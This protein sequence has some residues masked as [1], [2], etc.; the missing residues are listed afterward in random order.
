M[1]KI[2]FFYTGLLLF[3]S[4][5][6]AQELNKVV[7]KYVSYDIETPIRVDCQYFV[8]SFGDDVKMI[9]ITNKKDL[10]SFSKI[11]KNMI[12]DT[13]QIMPD[14]RQ[15]IEVF[16]G[17]KLNIICMDESRMMIDEKPYKFSKE[18]F[19]YIEKMKK[20]YKGKQINPFNR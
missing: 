11:F 10:A 8:T 4:L 5:T 15:K 2:C 20:K 3:A 6:N 16:N 18:L 1:F 12:A 19:G 9:T 13:I 7:I 14:V 17:N